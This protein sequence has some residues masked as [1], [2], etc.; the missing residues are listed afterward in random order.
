MPLD[1]HIVSFRDSKHSNSLV[2]EHPKLVDHT[3]QDLK[4]SDIASIDDKKAS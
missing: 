1:D 3:S 2:F 4:L